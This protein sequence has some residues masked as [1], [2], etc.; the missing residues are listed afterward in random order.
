MEICDTIEEAVNVNKTTLESI[1][2]TQPSEDAENTENSGNTI[3]VS[4]ISI[5]TLAAEKLMTLKI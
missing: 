5:S 2:E 1:E 4:E 3:R